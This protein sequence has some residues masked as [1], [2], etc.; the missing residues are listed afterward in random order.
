GLARGRPGG[1]VCDLMQARVSATQSVSYAYLHS[2]TEICARANLPPEPRIVVTGARSI[3]GT[4]SHTPLSSTALV[5]PSR[6]ELH[7]WSEKWRAY[8][9]ELLNKATAA[10]AG[11]LTNKQ[12]QAKA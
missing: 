6:A 12:L 9:Q 7:A 10:L 1:R 2:L 5:A 11:S 4:P 8:T 3:R